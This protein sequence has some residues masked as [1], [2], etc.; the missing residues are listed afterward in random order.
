MQKI[1]KSNLK[2]STNKKI[3]L[4]GAGK[5]GK[6]Y[7]SALSILGAKNV[8]VISR[9]KSK[10]RQICEQYGFTPIFG[11]YKEIFPKI[12][13]FDLVIVA[14]SVDLTV[15][16]VKEAIKNGQTNILLEKPGSIYKKD[17]EKLKKIGK[18]K[19][20]RIGYNRILYPNIRKLKEILKNETIT[21][22]KFS[23][24]EDPNRIPLKKKEFAHLH[25]RRG[26]HATGHVL[27]LVIELIGKPKKMTNFQSGNFQWHPSGSIFVGAGISER[28][29]PFSYHGDWNSK[30][31]WGIEILTKK[32]AYKIEPE[33]CHRKFP[34]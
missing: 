17:L 18:G 2:I 22:C 31:G 30:G 21:S 8:S 28:N 24:T 23:I 20:L 7:A 32:C 29:I 14:S 25:K 34:D 19:R 11:N 12:E 1:S 9:T 26:I 6:N 5:M 3:L 33:G 10:M 4:I 16:I 13:K 27:S 15:P